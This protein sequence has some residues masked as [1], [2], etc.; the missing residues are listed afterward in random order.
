MNR[1]EVLALAEEIIERDET[2]LVGTV[3]SKLYPNIKALQT[4]KRE[5]IKTFYF[6]T[7][8]NSRKVKQM[9]RRSKGCIY[10]F[11]KINYQT[12]LLEG[13]FKVEKNLMFGV[14]EL[15][16]LDAIDPYDFVTIKFT[17]KKVFVF[18]HKQTA[19]IVL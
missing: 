18:T 13:N 2:A 4:M 12:V 10:Y 16:K 3:S 17:A 9:K 19:E 7:K 15:Y 6:S 14:G 1:E 11:D 5:G 8:E